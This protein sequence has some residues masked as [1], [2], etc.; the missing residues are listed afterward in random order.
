MPHAYITHALPNNASPDS[1]A[2]YNQA[3]QSLAAAQPTAD[4]TI[5]PLEAGWDTPIAANHFRSGCAPITA[6]DHACKLIASGSHTAVRITGTDPLRSRYEADKA[7]RNTLMAIYG[8]DCP[9]PEAYTRLARA[10]MALHNIDEATFKDLAIDLYDN[11]AQ[12]ATV[13]GF[14]TEPKPEAFNFITELFRAVDCANPSID[15]H[16]SLIIS[17]KPL[18]NQAAIQVQATA[19]GETSGD[20]P[21][22]IDEIARYDHLRAACRAIESQVGISLKKEFLSGDALLEAYTCFP[23]V[24]LALLL[25]S[26]IADT[27]ADV[28][29][30]LAEHEITLTG[31]MN[32][33][34]AP[35]N[36]PA[37]HGLVTMHQ[38]LANPDAPSIGLVHANGGLGYKQGLALLAR[39]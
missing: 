28:P 8:A 2:T 37:L 20:G 7:R 32:I 39:V 15:F 1:I 25:S 26:G 6:L 4:L 18:T 10:F 29:E 27:L 33:A 23:V 24:P 34:R 38:H 22:H 5:D 16:A 21:A 12:T 14:Y 30:I 19:L 3:W 17:S 11:Y 35:W 13:E 31:G 36:N 9:I